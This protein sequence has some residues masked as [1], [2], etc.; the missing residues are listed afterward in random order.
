MTMTQMKMKRGKNKGNALATRF[1]GR[2][3]EI[4]NTRMQFVLIKKMTQKITQI[5]SQKYLMIDVR[6]VEDGVTNA[7]TAGATRKRKGDRKIPAKM[8]KSLQK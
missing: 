2:H 4:L 5:K 8:P 7:Q 6:I 3:V 1:K